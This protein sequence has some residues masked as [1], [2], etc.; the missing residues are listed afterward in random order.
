MIHQ[1]CIDFYPGSHGHFLEYVVNCWIFNGPRIPNIFTDNGTCHLTY[2]DYAYVS[3]KRVL[4]N[5]FSEMKIF[6]PE[7]CTKIIRIS[8]NSFFEECCLQMNVINRAGD[9]PRHIKEQSLPDQVLASVDRVRNDYYSKFLDRQNNAASNIEWAVTDCPVLEIS[10]ADLYDL[11]MFFAAL[12]K[13][14][15]FLNRKFTPDDELT[16]LWYKFV[17]LNHG[18][19]SWNLVNEFVTA[20][21]SN[22]E[23]DVCL[24][25]EEQALANVF[26]SQSLNIY[27]NELFYTDCY[28]SSTLEVRRLLNK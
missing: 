3:S 27:D 20:V 9:I 11:R 4:C 7:S 28:P 17:S 25:V 10:M 8:V 19:R 24:N 12:Q 2:G 1:F 18:L 22:R 16:Q 6:Y 13:I 5:H 15:Y 14:A 23:L 26:F 21:L